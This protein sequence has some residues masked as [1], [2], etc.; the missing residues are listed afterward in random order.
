MVSAL[1][2]GGVPRVLPVSLP[3][4]ADGR[5]LFVVEKSASTPAAY[6]RRPGIPVKRPLGQR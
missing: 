6:P 5:V 1:L 2:G 4:L 3:A